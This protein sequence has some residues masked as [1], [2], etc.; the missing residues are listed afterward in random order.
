MGHPLFHSI[1]TV[2][3][4]EKEKTKN[5]SHRHPPRDRKVHP[6]YMWVFRNP[7]SGGVLFVYRLG[8]GAK[9]LQHDTL[10]KFTVPAK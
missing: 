7:V 1:I 2:L 6:G 8:R 5:K 10:G 3:E 9:V 4:R